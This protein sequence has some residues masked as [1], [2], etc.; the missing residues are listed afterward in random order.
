M[1]KNPNACDQKH[2][3]IKFNSDSKYV[4]NK[5]IEILTMTVPARAVCYENNKFYPHVFLV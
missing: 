3:K 1:T 2:M 5:R 4:L